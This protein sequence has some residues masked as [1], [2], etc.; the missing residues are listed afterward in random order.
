MRKNVM[1]GE[2][3]RKVLQIKLQTV[4]KIQSHKLTT[5]SE[6]FDQVRTI[7]ALRFKTFDFLMVHTYRGLLGL[8]FST[9]RF[10]A[11]YCS[12]SIVTRLAN[13]MD[14]SKSSPSIPQLGP[15][16]KNQSRKPEWYNYCWKIYVEWVCIP[17][18][19]CFLFFFRTARHWRGL[20]RFATYQ[21]VKSY[22]QKYET[23]IWP[24]YY[25]TA[26]GP[27]DCRLDYSNLTDL[28]FWFL[29]IKLE[30]MN[31]H[32]GQNHFRIHLP[33]LQPF[34]R[35]I[36]VAYQTTTLIGIWIKT[37]VIVQTYLFH[38]NLVRS[39]INNE[40]DGAM[41]L[42]RNQLL[43][44]VLSPTVQSSTRC[45]DVPRWWNRSWGR[46]VTRNGDVLPLITPST[47]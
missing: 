31:K 46:W 34:F 35:S 36:G 9:N 42:L 25:S 2:A 28:D 30:N 37:E 7:W 15:G 16:Y 44:V 13:L 14:L 27:G 39:M 4:R 10:N 20:A 26:G 6:K 45:D 23:L 33:A 11:S 19:I 47:I 22:K 29:R 12:S 18:T 40:S 41:N 3:P 24:R 1:Q 32:E 43:K 17:L 8:C 5:N 38:G 21:S